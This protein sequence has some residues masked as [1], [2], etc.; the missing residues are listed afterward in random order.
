MR[1]TCWS[2]EQNKLKEK[3][4]IEFFIEILLLLANETSFQ[5]DNHFHVDFVIQQSMFNR[6]K[7]SQSF[8][9]G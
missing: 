3:K 1:S 2:S 5:D 7:K 6:S 8:K 9:G 4:D